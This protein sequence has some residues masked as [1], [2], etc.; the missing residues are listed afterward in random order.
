[1]AVDK[2]FGEKKKTSFIGITVFGKT[3]EF[4]EKYIK[5]GDAVELT[6][7]IDTGSY[8]KSDGT[9]VYTTDILVDEIKKIGGMRSADAGKKDD[10]VQYT[11]ME[12]AGIPEGFSQIDIDLPF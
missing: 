4:C 1:V 3:A 12:E 11:E 10:F 5:K 7:S 2:G 9:T 8:K 6:G